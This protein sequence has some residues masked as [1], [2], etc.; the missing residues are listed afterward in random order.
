MN[1]VQLADDGVV[2][3]EP[4]HTASTLCN[5]KRGRRRVVTADAG[6]LCQWCK[7]SLKELVEF[8]EFREP[9]WCTVRSWIQ[10]Q[11]A[12]TSPT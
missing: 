1:L 8:A 7:E 2:H 11:R 5:D 4:L 10:R 12:P 3:I 6:P 9:V